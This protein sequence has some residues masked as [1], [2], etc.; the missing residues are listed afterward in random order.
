MKARPLQAPSASPARW[1]LPLTVAAFAV[2]QL[3]QAIPLPSLSLSSSPSTQAPPPASP[4]WHRLENCRLLPSSTNDGDSF[5][6]SAAGNERIFRLYFADCPETIQRSAGPDRIADQARYFGGI[7]NDA[8][9]SAGQEA[10]AFTSDHLRSTPFTIF[11]RWER[12]FDSHRFYAHVS[13]PTAQ[14]QPTDLAEALAA[15]GLA[16][17]HT[18]GADHPLARPERQQLQHLRSLERKAKAA[19]LGAWHHLTSP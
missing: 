11:T 6:V 8:V 4:G 5:K 14:G 7:G 15:A 17:I 10:R 3:Q 1:L 18:T 9:I 12:V 13:L 16:R 2:V 19:R